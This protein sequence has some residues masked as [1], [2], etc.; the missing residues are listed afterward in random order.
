MNADPRPDPALAPKIYPPIQSAFAMLKLAIAADSGYAW[1]WHCNL[2]MPMIDQGVEPSLA[3]E[4][5]ARQM[6]HLF[7]FDTRACVEWGTRQGAAAASR[8]FAPGGEG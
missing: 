2:A 3:N 5:A 1:S 8:F 4:A 7:N 6:L